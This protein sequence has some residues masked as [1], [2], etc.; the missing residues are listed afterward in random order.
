MLMNLKKPFL[1]Q[2]AIDAVDAVRDQVLD[3]D[4]S[5]EEA[6]KMFATDGYIEF[7]GQNYLSYFFAPFYSLKSKERE[8]E[9]SQK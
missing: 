2:A 8:F 1:N 5:I 6:M 9:I 4:R 7:V 3:T